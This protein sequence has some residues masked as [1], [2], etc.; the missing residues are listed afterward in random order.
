MHQ[1]FSPSTIKDH[2][3]K[4]S[5]AYDCRKNHLFY[6]YFAKRLI[7]EIKETNR[8]FKNAVE[9]GCGSGFSTLELAKIVDPKTI[10][11]I[12]ISENMLRVAAGKKELRGVNFI[13]DLNGLQKSNYDL[14]FSS[15]SYHW[16]DNSFASNLVKLLNTNGMI[17]LCVPSEKTRLLFGNLILARALKIIPSARDISKPNLCSIELSNILEN[18]NKLGRWHYTTSQTSYVE[19]FINTKDFVSTLEARGSLLALQLLYNSDAKSLAYFISSQ[20]NNKSEIAMSWT[21]NLILITPDSF[22]Y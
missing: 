5:K 21:A 19:N 22:C 7:E 17:A 14:I 15:Y 20:A 16:W 8:E 9:I 12:D 6:G 2:Y 1:K 4:F 10:S 13:T 11:A 3:D 18:I